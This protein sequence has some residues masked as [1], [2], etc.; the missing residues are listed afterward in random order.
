M[1]FHGWPGLFLL[2]YFCK[3]NRKRETIEEHR[4]H[5]ERSASGTGNSFRFTAA[6]KPI[7]VAQSP[8]CVANPQ[9]DPSCC[10]FFHHQAAQLTDSGTFLLQLVN[11]PEVAALCTLHSALLCCSAGRTGCDWVRMNERLPNYNV[12]CGQS[13]ESN[14]LATC[15][16]IDQIADGVFV[17]RHRKSIISHINANQ[18]FAW[19][20]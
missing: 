3:T 13:G 20:A 4:A 19:T 9:G 14:H 15:V 17:P 5:S 18:L 8:W 10:G 16:N 7:F 12:H 2:G 6:A 1:Y 11:T